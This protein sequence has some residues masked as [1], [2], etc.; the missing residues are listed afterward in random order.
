[1]ADDSTTSKTSRISTSIRIV[2]AVLALSWIVFHASRH[3]EELKRAFLK[4]D[5]VALTAA[6]LF[7]MLANIVIG[8]RWYLLLRAQ[9][10]HIRPGPCIRIH[11]L[12]M[13]YNNILISSVG[14]DLLRAWYITKHTH[15]RLEAVLSVLVD[16][17][18]GLCTLMLV[19]GVFPVGISSQSCRGIDGYSSQRGFSP[20]RGGRCSLFTRPAGRNFIWLMPG[21]HRISNGYFWRFVCTAESPSPCFCRSG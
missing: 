20:W 19:S 8:C 16:R 7:F 9:H 5:P 1:L 17:V 12:G 11:F 15:K 10:I 21:W 2:V 14:G 6:I 13:F 3:P 18:V 4:L